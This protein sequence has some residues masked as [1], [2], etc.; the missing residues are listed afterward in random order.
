LVP[1]FVFGQDHISKDSLTILIT[2][3]SSQANV[4]WQQGKI[5]EAVDIFESLISLPG[6]KDY[7]RV[8]SNLFYNLACGYSL[9]DNKEKSLYYLTGAVQ[10]G[11]F[12]YETI[13]SDSDLKNIR[14]D[15]RFKKIT[16]PL[17]M[18]NFKWE[19][20]TLLSKY[21]PDLSEDERVAG[22]S[23]VWSETKYS[24]AYFD[25]VQ[26]LD[27]DS[28]YLAYLPEIRKATDIKD[29]YRILQEMVAELHDGHTRIEV[30]KEL[31]GQVYA[32]PPVE[33]QLIEDKVLIVKVLSDSLEKSGILPGQEIM[34]ID[35]I[36][37]HDYAR[38][39]VEPYISSSTEQFLKVSSYEVYLLC[40]S[41]D[42]QVELELRNKDGQLFKRKLVRNY[43]GS[44]FN[45]DIVNYYPIDKKIAYIALKTFGD[46]SIIVKFD[47]LFSFIQQSE[48]VII[49]LRD[50]GGGN[51]DIAYNIL[52][53]FVD[54]PFKIIQGKSRNYNAFD[55]A[56]K[57]TQHWG[58]NPQVELP[59]NGKHY[60]S[61]PVVVLESAKTGS[62]AEEFCVVLKSLNRAKFIGTSSAGSTGQP[63]FY[64]LPGGGKGLVCTT[65]SYSP[66]GKEF[67][68]IGL[69][70][71]II[72]SQSISDLQTGNDSALNAAISY[73]KTS[74]IQAEK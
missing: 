37:V 57:K 60:Y 50:N 53:Y 19:S 67:I 63:L 68:G 30:P 61:K 26:T 71:D 16:E 22:L 45:N 31:F 73:L 10:S 34:S 43:F 56:M 44:Q 23:K 1:L 38:L 3:N 13:I 65:R 62:S 33:T 11:Y 15:E 21:H 2:Q 28:L 47:S 14:L 18:S 51:T 48:A 36:P 40:G 9:L 24:Y 12:D 4:Y 35:G 74:G 69:K 29:Y 27:W 32:H 6:I 52:G 58:E 42:S 70:P 59:A 55:R 64:G 8:Y 17:K 7:G 25:H 72:V 5:K 49:D 66:D 39:N 41:K 20:P 46:K 54:K